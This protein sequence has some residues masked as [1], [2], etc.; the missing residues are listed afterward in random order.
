MSCYQANVLGNS[1]LIFLYMYLIGSMSDPDDIPG[2]A[3]FCEH[4]AFLGTK[5]VVHLDQSAIIINEKFKA[6]GFTL[7]FPLF[8]FLK[9]IN[10]PR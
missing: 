4:M 9:K 10:S 3:H 7:S 5:K 2:L 8:S 6:I 1:G